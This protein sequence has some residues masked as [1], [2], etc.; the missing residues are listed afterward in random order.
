MVVLV[1]LGTGFGTQ[2]EGVPLIILLLLPTGAI[3]DSNILKI[4]IN[5]LIGY[6]IQDTEDQ[7]ER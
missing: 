4:I 1:R 3:K 6:L 7:G 5:L 2:G